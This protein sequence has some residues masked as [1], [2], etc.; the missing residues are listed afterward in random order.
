MN[1]MIFI[2]CVLDPR[3]KFDYV[4]FVLS[5]MYGQEKGQQL[6]VEIKLYMTSL[7]EGYR[8]VTSKMS[9]GSSNSKV[10]PS[11]I[12]IGNIHERTL[13]QQ[14]YLRHKA[15]SGNMDAKIELDR[16]L[17]EDVDV[18]NE[19][20][21]ILLWW[22]VN[23]SKFPTLAEMARDVLAI[24]ISTVASESAFS[25]G[26]RVLDSFRSS[27]TP[28]LVQALIC[29]KDWFRKESS[30]IKVEEDLDH[31]EEI[32][33]GFWNLRFG[34]SNILKEMALRTVLGLSDAA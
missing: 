13:I 15:E 18:A 28:R 4:T 22:K 2:A 16:Y 14:E 30:P 29:L 11:G 9:Q 10:D 5:K 3:F 34:S 1:K 32:E 31:L 21:D 33:S 23:S 6:R 12:N 7:F 20:F 8:K 26:R 24:P 19:H 17:D 27:L 25:T